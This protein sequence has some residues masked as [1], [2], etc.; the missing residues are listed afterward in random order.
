MPCTQDPFTFVMIPTGNDELQ[1]VTKSKAGSPD[2]DE[3][4]K[5]AK[6]YYASSGDSQKFNVQSDLRSLPDLEITG[7]DVPRPANQYLS[8]TMY[9]DI[10]GQERKKPVNERATSLVSACRHLTKVIYGDAFLARA[11]GNDQIPW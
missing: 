7:L 2:D 10:N 9:S 6:V 11:Y 4:Q 1:E 5:Y 8:V 3:L